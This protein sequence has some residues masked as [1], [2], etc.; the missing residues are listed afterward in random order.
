MSVYDKD[1]ALKDAHPSEWLTDDGRICHTA[2]I[3]GK[4]H[5]EDS[6]KCNDINLFQTNC[7]PFHGCFCAPHN[8][9]KTASTLLKPH[10]IIIFF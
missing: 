3:P 1:T 10:D 5:N 4:N 8:H 9:E 6:V 7:T 2:W